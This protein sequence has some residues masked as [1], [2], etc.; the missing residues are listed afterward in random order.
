MVWFDFR[1]V[2]ILSGLCNAQ[3]VFLGCFIS[4]DY[5]VA[6]ARFLLGPDF[7][8]SGMRISIDS[9]DQGRSGYDEDKT[10]TSSIFGFSCS[11]YRLFIRF[12]ADLRQHQ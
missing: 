9:L 6:V 7:L 4:W 1:R 10:S 3:F 12:P 2:L 5:G 8:N 11:N